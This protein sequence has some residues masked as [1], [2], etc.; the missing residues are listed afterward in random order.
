MEKGGC[1]QLCLCHEMEQLLEEQ[2]RLSFDGF[3]FVCEKIGYDTIP[4][5]LSNGECAFEVFARTRNGLFF[6]T[7][8]FRLESIDVRH[9]CATLSLLLP[10][11]MDGFPVELCDEVFSLITTDNC[12]IV[13]LS[14]F[15]SIQ[16]LSPKLVNRELPIVEPKC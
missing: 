2:K 13:D 1:E 15:C 12:I 4:F 14:C 16:P 9:C 3:R 10:I 5:T 6:T 8:V 7:Q 11:D